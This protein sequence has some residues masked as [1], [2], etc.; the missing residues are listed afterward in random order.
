MHKTDTLLI[1]RIEEVILQC[2]Q[3][4]SCTGENP[5]HV[6]VTK[7]LYKDIRSFEQALSHCKKQLS[8]NSKED[9]PNFF[10][11]HYQLTLQ[12]DLSEVT[13]E[14]I[15]QRIHNFFKN[16][17]IT[18]FQ[19]DNCL[20]T[21]LE[22]I[23]LVQTA[24]EAITTRQKQLKR[25][26]YLLSKKQKVLLDTYT[27][28]STQLLDLKDHMHQ[29]YLQLHQMMTD[30]IIIHFCFLYQYLATLIHLYEGKCNTNSFIEITSVI[31][32]FKKILQAPIE[33]DTLKLQQLRNNYALA[34]FNTLQKYLLSQI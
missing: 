7:P 27:T 4:F 3:A 14:S 5:S 31:D 19:E 1:Q 16:H 13:Y 6:S 8:Q 15:M 2:N 22:D 12:K 21:L 25:Y 9:L 10:K 18:I 24:L 11:K 30:P 32:Y 29:S 23:S 26:K 33:N 28:K 17:S 20:S 34:E